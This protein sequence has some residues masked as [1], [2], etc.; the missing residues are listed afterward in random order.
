MIT[1]ENLKGVMPLALDANI[2]KY[3]AELSA[4]M[5]LYE[6][7]TPWRIA[8]FL[9]NIGDESGSLRYA[10]EL[11]GPTPQQLL[12]ERDFTQPW[13][14]GLKRADRNFSSYNL[15]ND[16]KGDGSKFRGHGLIQNTGK[17][18]HGLLNVPLGADFV[19]KPELLETPHYACAAAG[20]FWKS[21]GINEFADKQDFDG[22]CDKV[23]IGVKTIRV[24]DSINFK[25]RLEFFNRAKAIFHL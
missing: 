2:T 10:K 9:A 6:I 12:Y 14:L 5:E 11:W 20:F 16:A 4:A 1:K 3:L 7:N 19:T 15:G 24:G 23:N 13:I 22:T 8:C 25:D 21:N 17:K 18:N